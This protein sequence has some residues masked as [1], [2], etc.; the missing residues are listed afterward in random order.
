MSDLTE[1]IKANHK[2]D[3]VRVY[4]ILNMS[5]HMRVALIISIFLRREYEEYGFING[6]FLSPVYVFMDGGVGGINQGTGYRSW[7]MMAAEVTK[8]ETRSINAPCSSSRHS[9]RH[10][11]SR[12]RNQV[13]LA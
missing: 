6:F 5:A 4:H 9:P 13:V 7:Q 8:A 1:C 11:T 3:D 12:H 2:L 10:P